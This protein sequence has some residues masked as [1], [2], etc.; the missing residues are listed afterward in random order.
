MQAIH[1]GCYLLLVKGLSFC[2]YNLLLLTDDSLDNFHM[3]LRPLQHSFS[4]FLRTEREL[5]FIMHHLVIHVFYDY[6]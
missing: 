6:R 5:S 4:W 2:V 1:D 3:H